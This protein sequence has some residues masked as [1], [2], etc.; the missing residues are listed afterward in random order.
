MPASATMLSAM[1]TGSSDFFAGAAA[2]GAGDGAAGGTG[3]GGCIAGNA[4][5]G[6]A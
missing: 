1:I 6:G 3:A 4:G 5:G 2:T